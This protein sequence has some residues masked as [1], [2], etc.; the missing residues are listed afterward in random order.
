MSV[1]PNLE[2]NGRKIKIFEWNINKYVGTVSVVE[3]Q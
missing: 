3:S 2:F 1:Q